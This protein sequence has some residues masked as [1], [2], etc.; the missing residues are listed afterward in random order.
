MCYVH[1]FLREELLALGEG[2]SLLLAIDAA[3]IFHVFS[4]CLNSGHPFHQVCIST[5]VFHESNEPVEKNGRTS[6]DKM[7]SQ[8]FFEILYSYSVWLSHFRSVKQSFENRLLAFKRISKCGRPLFRFQ[9]TNVTPIINGIF[10]W[11]HDVLPSKPSGTFVVT[12]MSS[13]GGLHETASSCES[14]W[15]IVIIGLILVKIHG[16]NSS[17]TTEK[18]HCRPT[19]Q[20]G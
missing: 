17:A 10:E 5:I 3:M 8:C 4:I 19:F 9:F 18:W 20:Q 6:F 16:T 14:K 13:L 7:W 2:L 1:F 15:V 11:N 12:W